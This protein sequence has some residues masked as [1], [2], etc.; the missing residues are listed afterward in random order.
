MS[1]SMKL[2]KN[3]VFAYGSCDDDS[4]PGLA[5]MDS[6]TRDKLKAH[7]KIG[8]NMILYAY[9]IIEERQPPTGLESLNMKE[10]KTL[11]EAL[12]CIGHE[13]RGKIEEAFK[14]MP[15]IQRVELTAVLS[16]PVEMI[17]T[18]KGFLDTVHNSIRSG[19]SM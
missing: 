1:I 16:F 6:E 15:P 7:L 19:C 10:L 3:V 9:E 5:L 14:P 18:I 13:A 4:L 17:E 11:N 8:N 12:C 2:P